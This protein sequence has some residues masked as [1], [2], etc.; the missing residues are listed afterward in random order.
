MIEK[1]D[2]CSSKS[3]ADGVLVKESEI[4]PLSPDAEKP[5]EQTPIESP[6]WNDE[7]D[8]G[9]PRHPSWG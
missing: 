2:P 6:L 5:L 9:G 1:I 8:P 7:E 4:S 3:S